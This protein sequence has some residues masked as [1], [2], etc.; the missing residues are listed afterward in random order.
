MAQFNLADM[1]IKKKVLK[2]ILDIL[3]Q[4]LD[5]RGTILEGR[6]TPSP[7]EQPIRPYDN[8]EVLALTNLTAADLLDDSDVRTVNVSAF[9]LRH[10]LWYLENH[11]YIVNVGFNGR[12]F[13]FAY[14]LNPALGIDYHA[15][16][17]QKLRW[18]RTNWLP[19]LGIVVA[20][21]GVVINFIL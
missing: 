21:G 8:K 11:N 6:D 3:E 16:L 10:H 12:R 19:L 1:R 4:R 20:V 5:W 9:A 7:T 17:H 13:R 2:E 15:S 14:V 18:L